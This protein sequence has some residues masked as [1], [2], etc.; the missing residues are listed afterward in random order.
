MVRA[1]RRAGAARG[2]CVRSDRG[3]T[4]VEIALY[5]P[6]MLL[7]VMVIVQAVTWGLA[8]LS[9]RHAA[10]HGLQ[11]ARVHGATAADGQRVATDLLEEIN[12]RGLTDVAVE[13]V[14][15]D[16]STTVTVTGNALQVIP[17]ITIPIQAQAHGP[18]EPGG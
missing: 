7:A 1:T 16:E 15:D 12:P 3:D 4:S 5:A 10:N 14:R 2:G 8:D 17:V 11:T 18:T 6:L 13:V 9:A